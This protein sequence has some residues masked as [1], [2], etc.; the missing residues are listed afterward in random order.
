MLDIFANPSLIPVATEY[1]EASVE[2]KALN[3]GNFNQF[4]QQKV[5]FTIRD[6]LEGFQNYFKYLNAKI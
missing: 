6:F 4:W 5:I 3:F 2:T 1:S